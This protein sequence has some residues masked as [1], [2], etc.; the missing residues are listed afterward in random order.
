MQTNSNP[1]DAIIVGDIHAEEGQPP[2][3]VD[4]F[5]ETQ[6]RKFK[7]LR[8]IWEYS[9]QPV[10]I[11]VGD[12]FNHW[13]SSPKVIS[14]VLEYLPPMVTIPGNPGRHNYSGSDINKDALYTVS[15]SGK[16]WVVLGMNES[17]PYDITKSLLPLGYVHYCPWGEDPKPQRLQPGIRKILLTHRMIVD[18]YTPYD[19]DDAME[20]LKR[21][22]GYDLILTGH[23]HKPIVRT[24]NGRYLI[25]PGSFTRQSAGETH[26]PSVWFWWSESNKIERVAI[27]CDPAAITRQHIEQEQARDL[28]LEAFVESL[29][30]Q[31]ELDINYRKNV[32]IYV[33]NN[34]IRQPVLDRI[35]AAIGKE[36]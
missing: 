32:E 25:N 14:A 26:D 11:Q 15:V 6:I 24:F 7:W 23:N 10:V 8:G 22:R 19:G 5:W 2:C 36:K 13:K 12:L 33:A 9:S 17:S 35:Y 29:E 18:G 28:R 34:K 1:P 31:K 27:P 21:H 30:E 20:F 3:R 4:N 16:G